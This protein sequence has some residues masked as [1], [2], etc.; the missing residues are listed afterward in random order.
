MIAQAGDAILAMP[1][2]KRGQK[3]AFSFD[4]DEVAL[5]WD[6]VRAAQLAAGTTVRAVGLNLPPWWWQGTKLVPDANADWVLADAPTTKGPAVLLHKQGQTVDAEVLAA[7]AYQ[8]APNRTEME[9]QKHRMAR[10]APDTE[11]DYPLGAYV[12]ASRHEEVTASRMRMPE[13]KI[14]SWTQIGPGA[15][16]TEFIRLQDAVGAYHTVL[17][18]FADGSRTVGLWV[19]GQ[20]PATGDAVGPV[21]RRLFRTQGAWRHGVKFTP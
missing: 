18:E 6:A 21:L 7:D 4:E 13:G 3:L 14:V 17:V 8:R 15:A 12:L 2:T 10:D 16:P 20:P 5:A 11:A 19:G 9:W 1:S